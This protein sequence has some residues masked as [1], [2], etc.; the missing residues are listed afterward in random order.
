M[1]Q[2]GRQTVTSRRNFV[3]GT[4]A[5]VCAAANSGGR[6]AKPGRS[7]LRVAHL[8]DPQ[9]GFATGNPS[10]K[11]RAA[12]FS[13]RNR[14]DDLARCERAIARVNELKPDLVLFGG[15]MTQRPAEVT[16]EWPELLRR[17]TVP[18]MVTPGNHDM[19]NS[20][21]QAN[22]KR[23]RKAFGPDR[24]ARDIKGWRIIAGNSQFWHRTEAV[25]EQRAYEAWAINELANAKAYD[26]RVI[27]ATH[28]PPFAFKPDE[29]DSYDNCPRSLRSMR[30]EA[31][32]GSGARFY[33]SAHQ[34]RLV[35][36]GYKGLTILGAE[37]LCD[38]FDLR[39]QGFRMLE[40]ND[41]FSYAWHFVEV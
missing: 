3:L 36:R 28:I 22:L 8:C 38:N 13:E 27:L 4:A 5:A 21:T 25:E 41:D 32:A 34:H 14:K 40:L 33:L 18:W 35:V 9:F 1:E 29:K 7:T 30:L 26:G 16:T 12:E 11:W 10:M 2:K 37:A 19:G 23:F 31:Y 17:V 6:I 15:D 20:V 39:P 24:E